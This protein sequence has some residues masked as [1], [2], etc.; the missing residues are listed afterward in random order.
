[1]IESGSETLL[2][3]LAGGTCDVA[4]PA[5][6]DNLD[7]PLVEEGE[8]EVTLLLHPNGPK[9]QDVLRRGT[10]EELKETYSRLQLYDKNTTFLVTFFLYCK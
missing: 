9:V 1:M 2:D 7:R 5:S 10:R 4:A 3:S 6:E 8:V